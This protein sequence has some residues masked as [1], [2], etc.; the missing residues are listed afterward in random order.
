L[1]HWLLLPVKLRMTELNAW[2]NIA[3]G[4]TF[5]CMCNCGFCFEA[6]VSMTVYV[7][8]FDFR[9]FDCMHNFK[10]TYDSVLKTVA[11]PGGKGRHLSPGAAFWGRKLRL[12][13]H[14]TIT[15]YQ[16]SAGAIT[17]YEMSNASS[18]YP[19]EKS[20]QDHQGSQREQLRTLVTFSGVTNVFSNQHPHMVWLTVASQCFQ[21]AR[22]ANFPTSFSFYSWV[23][24]DE[25]PA[26]TVHATV[27]TFRAALNLNSMLLR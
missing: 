16:M 17:I 13:C 26:F 14:V 23:T 20:H 7:A 15:K 12:E 1:K 3:L 25:N 8:C 4:S 18:W 27:R 22:L 24:M 10:Q 2:K 5:R 21:I 19:V 9:I 6:Y 11:E